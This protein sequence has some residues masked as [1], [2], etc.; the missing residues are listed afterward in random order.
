V[1]EPSTAVRPMPSG[2]VFTAT[3]IQIPGVRSGLV[4]RARLVAL[5]A[6]AT[7][8]KLALLHPREGRR[9]QQPGERGGRSAAAV[10]CVRAT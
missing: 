2:A 7:E 9:P 10:K 1:T 4:P 3:K 6:G 8:A 5:L